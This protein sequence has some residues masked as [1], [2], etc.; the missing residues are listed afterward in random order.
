MARAVLMHRGWIDD[1]VNGRQ[2]NLF[3]LQLLA[4]RWE[5]LNPLHFVKDVQR[6][7]KWYL[8]I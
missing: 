7:R 8:L 3:I 2:R 6:C 1:P 5:Q 4:K